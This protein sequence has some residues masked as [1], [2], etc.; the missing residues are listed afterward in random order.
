LRLVVA[1]LV[2]FVHGNRLEE[3]NTL[4]RNLNEDETTWRL[5]HQLVDEEI[6]RD[7]GHV[8]H[9]F[10][11]VIHVLARHWHPLER[12]DAEAARTPLHLA[13]AGNHA[14]SIEEP[15]KFAEVPIGAQDRWGATALHVAAAAT[16]LAAVNKLL[17]LGASVDATNV[18][19]E[20]PLHAA[21]RGRSPSCIAALLGKGGHW[22]YLRPESRRVLARLPDA[23]TVPRRARPPATP[24][25]AG[26]LSWSIAQPRLSRRLKTQLKSPRLS[27]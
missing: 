1:T 10:D 6:G 4:L 24:P 19:G 8:A 5:S 26:P 14:Q 25:Q 20:T 12:A 16:N 21:V 22:Q 7:I 17:E 11:E 9:G 27:R 2:D 18:E 3:L 15:V 23:V 13:A